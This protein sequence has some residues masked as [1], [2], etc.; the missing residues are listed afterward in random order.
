MLVETKAPKAD[1]IDIITDCSV[2]TD[3]DILPLS[4]PVR[5]IYNIVMRL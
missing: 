2:P 1:I 3:E 4:N 5:G